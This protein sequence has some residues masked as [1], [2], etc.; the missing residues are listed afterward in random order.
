MPQD[1]GIALAAMAVYTL[2][3]FIIYSFVMLVPCWIIARR[4][5]VAGGWWN[6]L[7]PFWNLYTAYK[8]GNGPMKSGAVL[9][10]L[11]A[12]GSVGVLFAASKTVMLGGTF[13]LFAA[14]CLSF[15]VLY[16]WL[17]NIS[18][19]A[20]VH[21]LVLPMVLLILPMAVS[22]LFTIL[23]VAR[24]LPADEVGMYQYVVT[25]VSWVI[26]AIIALCTP[27]KP[28]DKKDDGQFV[29]SKN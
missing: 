18:I 17:R 22:V 10:C 1:S 12:V 7:I 8:V 25:L 15:Y 4:R 9:L 24:V 29:L 6:W 13:L 14:L 21:P 5:G 23:A 27:R 11:I 20:G 16:I 19:L 3:A 28:L 26:F 2:L